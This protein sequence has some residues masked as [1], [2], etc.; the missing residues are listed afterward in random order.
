MAESIEELVLRRLQP[1]PFW[2]HLGAVLVRASPGQATVRVPKRPEFGRS[3]AVGEASAHG[4]IIASVVDMAAS[5]ALITVLDEDE[6]RAT[7]DLIV[8]YLA[9]AMADVEATANVRRKG[10]RT[11]V[12]DIEV[13]SDGEL[14]ALGRATFAIVLPRRER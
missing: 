8:H 5:C 14:V 7:L 9:A 4:G 1:A 13:E 10:R 6:G 3:G 12:I 2:D 11:A